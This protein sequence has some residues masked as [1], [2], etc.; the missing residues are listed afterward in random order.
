MLFLYNSSDFPESTRGS[1]IFASAIVKFP[2]S[3]SQKMSSISYQNKKKK[4]FIDQKS[5]KCIV[6][7]MSIRSAVLLI[8]CIFI[9]L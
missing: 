1:A 3:L 7:K 5:K 9:H 8:H 2:C 4:K 6:I